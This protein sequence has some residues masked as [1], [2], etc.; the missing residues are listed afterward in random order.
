MTS[1]RDRLQQ[2]G[3]EAETAVQRRLAAAREEIQ[4]AKERNV[5]DLVIINDDLDR[6][7]ELFRKAALGEEIAGDTLPLLGD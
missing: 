5:H 4:Y 7:Y 2:R 1:L 6:A 3:T